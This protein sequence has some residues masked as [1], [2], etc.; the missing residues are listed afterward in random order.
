LAVGDDHRQK[1]GQGAHN[2]HCAYELALET[3]S[4]GF[5]ITL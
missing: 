3:H 1:E 5:G 4:R 2:N